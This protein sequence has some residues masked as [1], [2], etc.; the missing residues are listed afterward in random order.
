MEKTKGCIEKIIKKTIKK[1]PKS[2]PAGFWS[3]MQETGQIAECGFYVPVSMS[4]DDPEGTRKRILRFS[5]SACPGGKLETP[6][7]FRM[8][9]FIFQLTTN[10]H[11]PI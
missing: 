3:T 4:R 1:L 8:A 10:N 5:E 9:S 2:L 11:V 7:P 6:K